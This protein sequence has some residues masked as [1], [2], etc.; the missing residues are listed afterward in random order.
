[1]ML[2]DELLKEL[3][4]YIMLIMDNWEGEQDYSA[5]V[6]KERD[7]W[8]WIAFHRIEAQYGS[9]K[10]KVVERQA[11]EIKTLGDEYERLPSP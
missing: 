11:S 9:T 6:E 2:K 4:N 1:M 8:K 7:R 10:R 3:D 5:A